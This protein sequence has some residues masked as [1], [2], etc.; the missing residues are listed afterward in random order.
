MTGTNRGF[1]ATRGAAVLLCVVIVAVV[2][3][4]VSAASPSSEKEAARDALDAAKARLSEIQRQI[5]AIEGELMLKAQELDAAEAELDST[6]TE[7]FRVREDLEQTHARYDSIVER[8]NARA[9]EAYMTGPST[10]LDFLLGATSISD[11]SDRFEYVEAVARSDADLA[12]DVQ[13]T[14]NV[15]LAQQGELQNL[16]ARHQV[17]VQ[18]AK[19]VRDAVIETLDR[20]QALRAEQSGVVAAAGRKYRKELREYRRSLLVVHGGAPLPARYRDYFHTCPVG[21]P[22]SYWDGFGAPRYAGGYH[23]HKGVD[24]LAPTGTPIYAPFSGVSHTDYNALGGKVV[25][26]DGPHGRV[27]N[28]HLSAYSSRSNGPVN[29]GDV[30]GYVGDTGDAIGTP[31]LHFEFHPDVI[32]ASWPASSYGYS[33]IE[34][35]INPYPLVAYACG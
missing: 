21:H 35:A 28:A 14:K 10:S 25:F 7:L 27:Y 5:D 18:E 23:L 12:Q 8:L 1:P 3:V 24:M 32:P 13:S 26:V 11:L 20:A 31:H 4:G 6:I 15:L 30:I 17:A 22:R 16:K 34:D 9:V 19:E 29:S 33:V 2:S